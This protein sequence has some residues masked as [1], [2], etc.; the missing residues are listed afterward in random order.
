LV[1]HSERKG[2][3]IWQYKFL[4]FHFV[5]WWFKVSSNWM[6]AVDLKI[7]EKRETFFFK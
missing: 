2:C 4:S 3:I 1:D 6:E 7:K 5:L